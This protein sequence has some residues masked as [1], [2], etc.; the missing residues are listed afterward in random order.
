MF[1]TSILVK[2]KA[3]ILYQITFLQ[4]LPLW[5]NVWKYGIAEQDR[6]DK[7]IIEQVIQQSQ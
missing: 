7:A 6:D 4:I 3:R 5:I 1:R 2:I